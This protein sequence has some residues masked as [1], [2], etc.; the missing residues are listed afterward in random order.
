[1]DKEYNE[2][3]TELTN[4]I[5]QL[6]RYHRQRDIRGDNVTGFIMHRLYDNGSMSPSEL[7]RVLGVS[8]PRVTIL[9]KDMEERGLIERSVV[10][11]DRRSV[12]ITLTEQ[13]T[14]GIEERMKQRRARVER[15]A[16]KIGIDDALALIRILNAVRELEDGD[17]NRI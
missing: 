16:D 2:I 15:L 10:A 11:S 14:K 6:R 5:S 3:I 1:M 4:L 8:G 13:G 12:A 7:C 9:L 17:E